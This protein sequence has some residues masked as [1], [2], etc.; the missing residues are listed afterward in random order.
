MQRK[1][2]LRL[3]WHAGAGAG[4]WSKGGKADTDF[5]F[6]A[7]NQGNSNPKCSLVHHSWLAGW[8][9]PSHDV[10]GVRVRDTE[11]EQDQEAVKAHV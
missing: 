5:F 8:L 2:A 10:V 9:H 3:P 6:G 7:S 1:R 11:K 4:V